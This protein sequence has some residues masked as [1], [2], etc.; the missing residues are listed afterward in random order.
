MKRVSINIQK[1]LVFIPIANWSLLFVWLYNYSR[2]NT[3]WTVFG[4]S[5]LLLFAFV[6]IIS[7]MNYLCSSFLSEPV[8]NIVTGLGVYTSPLLLGWMLI[9]YQEKTIFK[10]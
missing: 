4:K 3:K 9:I 8:Y 10:S 7:G 2:S 6:L 1:I 5:L